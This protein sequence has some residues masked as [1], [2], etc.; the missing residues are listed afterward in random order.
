M[1]APDLH[2]LGAPEPAAVGRAAAVAVLL[3]PEAGDMGTVLTVRPDHLPRHAG[4]VSLPGGAWEE[5]DRDLAATARRETEE[6]LGVTLE[7]ATTLGW[8]PGRYI[9]VSG[10]HLSPLVL[11]LPQRPEVRPDPREVA[12]VLF[13]LLGPLWATEA[14][15]EYRGR[16]WPVYWWQGYR[17]WGATAHVLASL[18]RAF[19]AQ[20]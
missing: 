7:G 15:E 16:R 5:G 6:E 11:W 12:A 17:I 20:R 3:Y 8:L 14:E 10:F 9:A 13:P 2:L 18:R 19:T 4:Q 1:Q